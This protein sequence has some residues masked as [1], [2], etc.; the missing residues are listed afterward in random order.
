MFFHFTWCEKTQNS[1]HEGA[2]HTGGTLWLLFS[3]I[4]CISVASSYAYECSLAEQKLSGPVH[5]TRIQFSIPWKAYL[6]WWEPVWFQNSCSNSSLKRQMIYI[7][8]ITPV[9]KPSV[10]F[11]DIYD[12]SND[13]E[14][15]FL[16]PIER[17]VLVPAIDASHM[18]VV[19]LKKTMLRLSCP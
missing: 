8:F 13:W 12:M 14:V 10:L 18:I 9:Q 19:W 16:L 1:W 2:D 3:G 4:S 15:P 5:H 11:S 17:H 6:C 7:L